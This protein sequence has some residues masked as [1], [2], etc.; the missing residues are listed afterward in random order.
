MDLGWGREFQKEGFKIRVCLAFPRNNVE[1]VAGVEC[2]RGKQYK[3]SQWKA[4][5]PTASWTMI[6]TS[7]LT[8]NRVGSRGRSDMV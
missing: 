2:M 8:A 3:K 4:R 5:S 6:R 7:A 1:V